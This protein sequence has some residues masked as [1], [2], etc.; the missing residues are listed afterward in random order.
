MS[1][2]LPLQEERDAGER[3]VRAW[4]QGQDHPR[5]RYEVI[6]L[7]PGLEP[8]LEQAAHELATPHDR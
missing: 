3:C 6:L 2:L 7:A 8:E 4:T 1:V 5:E